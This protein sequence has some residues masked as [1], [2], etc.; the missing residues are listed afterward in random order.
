MDIPP[1]AIDLSGVDTAPEA[2]AFICGIDIISDVA[3]ILGTD[4]AP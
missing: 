3:V 4:T 2:E 1:E